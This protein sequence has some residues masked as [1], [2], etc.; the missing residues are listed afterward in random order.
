MAWFVIIRESDGAISCLCRDADEC[1]QLSPRRRALPAGWR[2]GP[3]VDD[4]LNAAAWAAHARHL[5][6]PAQ[7]AMIEAELARES[8]DA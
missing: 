6:S 2:I 8:D 4:L 1:W 5:L 7:L 3:Q